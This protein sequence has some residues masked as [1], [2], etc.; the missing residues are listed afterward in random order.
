MNNKGQSL[1][2]FII[3][4]PLLVLLC[5]VVIELA[6][7][8]YNKH[9]VLSVT[10][11]IINNILL[12]DKKL[13]ENQKDDIIKMYNDNDIVV[14]DLF[15]ENNGTELKITGTYKTDSILGRLIKKDY[16]IIEK[17]IKGVLEN[18]KVTFIKG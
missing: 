14:D 17:N 15:I 1:T 2:L 18:D 9:R 7:L 12:S 10:K 6:N 11:T 3:I 4:V 16:Y 13:D 8:A 5:G